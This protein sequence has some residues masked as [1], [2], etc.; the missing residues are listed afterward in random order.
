MPSFQDRAVLKVCGIGGG[1]CNA[2]AR[3]IGD[4]LEGV[5]FI[6]VNTDAQ[7]LRE[8][9]AGQRLQIGGEQRGGLGAGAHP[10]VGKE[11]AEQDRD[12][13]KALF[14]GADMIFLTA[15]LGGGTGTGAMP[16][17]AEVSREVGALTVAIVTLPFSFEGEKRN[18]NARQGLAELQDKVDTL[19]VVPNDRLTTTS[20]NDIPLLKS[21]HRADE[22]LHNGVRA[23][24]EVINVTGMVNLDFA[25]VKTIVK[26]SGR[27]LMGIGGAEGEDRARIAAQTAI[28]CPLLEQSTID[29]ARGV[30]VNLKAGCDLGMRELQ[31]ALATVQSAA[32]P[33]ANI[34]FG[35]MLEDEESPELQ[36]TVIAANFPERPAV[37]DSD[38]LTVKPEEVLARAEAD[39]G[40]APAERDD[41]P[42]PPMPDPSELAPAY[43]EA[44]HGAPQEQDLFDDSAL[45]P[46]KA[47][48]VAQHESGGE[49]E[50]FFIP[51]FMR[52]RMNGQDTR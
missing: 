11:A 29:G 13:I 36:V 44:P 23:I 49:E 24:T 9:P 7:A 8:S 12:K 4:G 19:I 50:A 34:I 26:D 38:T 16:V 30:I 21:F 18:Q 3:M 22:A 14:E 17:I 1:G 28:H 45:E 32:H 15:G 27:A 40:R 25:D 51:A 5:D 6:A 20:D 37:A 39:K 46:V 42:E 47:A 52:R 48:Q 2:I 35:A 41:A 43:A 10:E 31:E 33:E